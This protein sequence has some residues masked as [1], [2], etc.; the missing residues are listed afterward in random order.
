MP[1]PHQEWR[2]ACGEDGERKQDAALVRAP[3][4]EAGQHGQ[5]RGV[6]GDQHAGPQ[7]HCQ[8]VHHRGGRRGGVRNALHVRHVCAGRRPQARIALFQEARAQ[9][10]GAAGVVPQEDGVRHEGHPDHHVR[11]G[12][13]AAEAEERR[14]AAGAA[15][16]ADA[17]VVPPGG[18]HHVPPR[19]PVQVEEARPVLQQPR[20]H[21]VHDGEVPAAAL[22]RVCHEGKAQDLPPR[23]PVA[24]AGEDAPQAV[25]WRKGQGE[26]HHA[27]ED[28][29]AGHRG[30]AHPAGPEGEVHEGGRRRRICVRVPRQHG[31]VRARDLG[32][33][34]PFRLEPAGGRRQA[35]VAQAQRSAH[36]GGHGEPAPVLHCSRALPRGDHAT[37]GRLQ[38]GGGHHLRQGDSGRHFVPA[39]LHRHGV[40]HCGGGRHVGVL[41]RGHAHPRPHG[42]RAGLCGPLL[43]VPGHCDWAAPAPARVRLHDP[44]VRW[45]R[46]VHA[47]T[48]QHTHTHTHR[49]HA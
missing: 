15:P 30:A 44:A 21:A 7:R 19:V 42:Q 34:H 37:R 43:Q 25:M 1:V 41:H 13:A 24:G 20:G 2:G 45:G 49:Q 6:W 40:G 33:P 4:R 39:K 32:L 10:G 11:G 26:V 48:K 14:A 29:G 9:A 8:R 22:L 35:A 38:G 36:R 5:G 31:H 47:H 12:R 17:Q 46:G 27:D 28:G 23:H 16:R 18:R 3:G